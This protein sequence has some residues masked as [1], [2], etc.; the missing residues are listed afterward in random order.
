MVEAA[1]ESVSGGRVEAAILQERSTPRP[2]PDVT[3]LQGL[4]RQIKIDFAVQKLAELGVD[5]IVVFEVSRSVPRW[6]EDKKENVRRRWERICHEASKQSRRAWLPELEGPVEFV[7]AV[8]T[9]RKQDVCF[10]ADPN[11]ETTLRAAL[12]GRSPGSVG[13]VVG[14]EGGLEDREVAEFSS[15]GGTPVSIG[16]QILRTETAGLAI[17]AVLMFH[18]GRLG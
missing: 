2:L 18:F 17:A 4:A 8:E 6:D 11:S 1:I 10:V 16:G 3:V 15:A 13:V 9:S 7:Q 12:P 14:P 5:R